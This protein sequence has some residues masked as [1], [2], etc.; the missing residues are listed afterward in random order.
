MTAKTTTKAPAVRKTAAPRNPVGIVRTE[1]KH[2]AVPTMIRRKPG[3]NPRFDFGEI[4]ELADSIKKNGLL[5]PLRVKPC[6]PSVLVEVSKGV[7]EVQDNLKGCVYELID[8]D[9]RL[10]AIELLIKKGVSFADGVW[11]EEVAQDQDDVTSLIQMFEANTGKPLLPLEEAA[12]FKRMREAKMTISQIS[13]AV[14][15]SVPTITERLALLESDDEVI[16]AVK[17]GK[18]KAVTAQKIAVHARGDKAKQ[19]EL[20]AQAT[21]VG[22]D[23]TKRAALA[24]SLATTQRDKHAK[25]GHVLK[26]RALSDADLSSHGNRMAESLKTQMEGKGMSFDTDLTTWVRADEELR[27][28]Y[29]FGALEALKMAAGAQVTL[30]A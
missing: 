24:K 14:Q 2:F 26:I 11:I 18:V 29:A 15:R 27:I 28:A 10:T 12:A 16:A 22:K 9:R 20:I 5:F 19:R 4:N 25:K 23:K 1:A 8:G 21:A 3:F 7:Y 17:G 30:E 6:S 13:H